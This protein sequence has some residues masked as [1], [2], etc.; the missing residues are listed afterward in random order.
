MGEIVHIDTVCQCNHLLGEKTLHPLVSVIDLSKTGGKHCETIKADF[1][2]IL[3]KEYK[4]DRFAFG[5]KECDY[6]SATVLFLPPGES[7]E[8]DGKWED[9][10]RLSK[11]WLIAFHPDFI[12]N[13]ALGMHIREYGFLRYKH[14]EALHLSLRETKIF[15]RC[16]ETIDEELH[17]AIDKHS[18]LL[19]SKSIELLLDYCKRFYDRQ[20][21]T[22]H[23]PNKQLTDLLE[24]VTGD[25]FTHNH[26]DETGLPSLHYFSNLLDASPSYLEDLLKHETGKTFDEY[27]RSKQIDLA[28]S[29]LSSTNK[30]PSQISKELGFPSMAY[31]NRVFKQLTGYAPEA[32]KPCN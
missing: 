13:T 11:G 28:K 10:A 24:K 16:V 29:W 1:Y 12:R 23:L 19:V 20:F 27:L 14:D 2:S 3:L 30:T 15:M 31:F 9:D 22:R 6:S 18:R 8:V 4:P 32:Y 5:R 17:R 7:F 25:Y 26:V 21:I